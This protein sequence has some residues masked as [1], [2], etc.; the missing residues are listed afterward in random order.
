[1]PILLFCLGIS[2][3]VG[4]LT[5]GAPQIFVLFSFATALLYVVASKIKSIIQSPAFILASYLYIVCALGVILGSSL[6]AL[7]GTAG[8]QTTL[9]PELAFLTARLFLLFAIS[10]LIGAIAVARLK[11]FEGLSIP[12]FAQRI[13]SSR[14]ANLT[15]IIGLCIVLLNIYAEG[16]GNL[17]DRGSRFGQDKSPINAVIGVLTLISVVGLG[18]GFVRAKLIQRLVIGVVLALD[19]FLYFSLGSRTFGLLPV[20]LLFGSV[21]GGSKGKLLRNSLVTAVFTIVLAPVALFSRA[22]SSHG[23]FPYLNALKGLKYD[24]ATLLSTTNNFVNGFEIVGTTAFN[25]PTIPW[26]AFLVSVNPSLGSNAGWYELSDSL[27][28]NAYTPYGALGEIGNRGLL[29]SVLAGLAVGIYF[30]FI[31]RNGHIV[32]SDFRAQILHTGAIGLSILAIV[33]CTQYNLRSD[34]RLL[35]YSLC[36]EIIALVIVKRAWPLGEISGNLKIISFKDKQ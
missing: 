9:S 33:Q 31:E 4:M 10:T 26:E 36:L 32:M 14:L 21:L 19:F 25:Q 34:V 35:Y 12:D 5:I 30:G 23:F 16:I 11:P 6:D 8:A 7:G 1:M 20:L 15:A 2:L 13:D 22:Q 24:A 27:R 29:F 18:A 28:L 17:L 3:F